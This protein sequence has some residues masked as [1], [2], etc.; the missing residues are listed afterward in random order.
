M[1]MAHD[2]PDLII[3]QTGEGQSPTSIRWENFMDSR[4]DVASTFFI[5]AL[6][7]N[8]E[9]LQHWLQATD[10]DPL[11]M[12]RCLD[13]DIISGVFFYKKMLILKLPLIKHW[14]SD[15]HPA[16][17]LICLKNTLIILGEEFLFSKGGFLP[18]ELFLS[19]CRQRAIVS[20]LFALLDGLI[21][22]SSDLTLQMRRAVDKL[23][24]D[25]LDCGG[26][27]GKKLLDYKR[28]LAHF[29]IA[30]EAKHRTLTV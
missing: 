26:K 11:I 25:M 5:Q 9:Q 16:I 15:Q 30:L 17:T 21:D 7:R 6:N 24:N 12:D 3:Y 10:A 22:H 29:E 2:N 14:E 4:N 13:S 20:M 27:F 18:D 28:D 19:V 8:S 23:E 1:D